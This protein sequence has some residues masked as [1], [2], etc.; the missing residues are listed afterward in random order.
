MLASDDAA[1][2][3]ALALALGPWDVDVVQ[4]SDAGP[5]PSMPGAAERGASLA[6]AHGAVAVAWISLDE[7]GASALWM[8]D[9]ASDRVLARRLATPPPFDEPT[10]VAVALSIKTL[11]RHSTAAPPDQ[12]V[13]EP[14]APSTIR[15]ELGGG[16]RAL[17]THPEDVEARGVLGLVGWVLSGPTSLGLSLSM[18]GGSGIGVSAASL[19]GR[20]WSWDAHVGVRARWLLGPPLDLTLGLELG[21]SVIDLDGRAEGQ[22]VRRVDVDPTGLLWAELAVRV[23]SGMRIGLRVG[24]FGDATTRSYLVRGRAAMD[25]TPVGLV[26]ELVLEVP[27]DGGTVDVR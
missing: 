20:L 26:T 11:L 21:I 8:Y 13:V 2:V 5:G 23:F 24:A 22:S 15:L 27:L 14:I 1:L 6:R 4:V 19:V 12:R 18:R 3:T 16:V 10:A 7:T 17:A 9:A 25:T